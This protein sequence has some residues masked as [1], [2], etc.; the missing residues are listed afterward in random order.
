MT[1]LLDTT[2]SG[3]VVVVKS[4][5]KPKTPPWNFFLIGRRKIKSINDNDTRLSDYKRGHHGLKDD[6]FVTWE[7]KV[8]DVKN[9]SLKKESKKY[10]R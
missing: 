4:S 8:Y 6:L 7:G 9:R 2:K 5:D 10:G 3:V 1:P